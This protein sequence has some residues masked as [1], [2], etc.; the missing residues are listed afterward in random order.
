MT[1][2]NMRDVLL[3]RHPE[4]ER[5]CV[6]AGRAAAGDGCVILVEGSAGIGKTRLLDRAAHEAAAVG[7][8]VL[9]A[10]GGELEREFSYGVARQLLERPL[11]ALS[12]PARQAA[13]DGAA[14]HAAPALGLPVVTGGGQPGS[15]SLVDRAFSVPHGLYWLVANLAGDRPL[16][17]VV[18]DLQWADAA[19][20]R[21]LVHLV[22]RLDGLAVLV[23]AAVRSAEDGV[24][25]AAL[26]ALAGDRLTEVLR[27]GPLSE[28]AVEAW[29]AAAYGRQPDP[30][31][32]RACRRVTGGNP[33][34]V[35]ELVG[36]LRATGAGPGADAVARVAELGP[37]TVAR[38]I[39]MRLGGQSAEA[40]A[41][42]RAV[43]LL[44]TEAPLAHAAALAGLGVE[45]AARAADRLAAV[46]ILR[47]GRPLEFVHP[48][49]RTA[50]HADLSPAELA[51]GHARAAALLSGEGADPERIA[52]HLLATDPAGEAD[53]VA[54]M[55]A[56]AQVALERGAPDSAA[57]F[58]RRA[59]AEPPPPGE[60]AAVEGAL[61]AA[62]LRAGRV[63]PAMRHLRGAI[64]A[65]PP[66]PARA[67]WGLALAYAAVAM[68]DIVG[69]VDV[70]EEAIKE[71]EGR[72]AEL[73]RR[74]EA[75]LAVAYLDPQAIPCVAA[76]LE[77]HAS[78]RG[79]TPGER[80]LLAACARALALRE[81]PAARAVAI[82]RRAVE[83]GL[84]QDPGIEE[85][86]AAY[87]ALW[88]LIL[89]ERL[90][91]AQRLLGAGIA[92]ARKLGYSL[93]F[94]GASL[95]RALARLAAGSVLDAEA[96]AR[97]AIGALD[98]PHGAA[99]PA[100]L[101]ALVEAL[102][103]QG[104]LDEAHEALATCHE[105]L[106]SSHS[107]PV[108]RLRHS[109]ALLH[110]AAGRH[111]RALAD[112]LE[113]GRCEEVDGFISPLVPWRDVAARALC[114]LHRPDEARPLA[115]CQAT[116]ARAY[117]TKSL[118]GTSLRLDAL[119]GEPAR[120]T[121]RLEEA[122]AL[123]ARSPARLE[124][125]RALIDLGTARSRDGRRTEGRAVLEQ[126][127]EGARRCGAHALAE[128]AREELRALGARPRRR[129]FSGVEALTA[130]ERRVAAMAAQGRAN[131]E[132][133]Q[134]L[135]VTAKT[136]E[137]HL[138]RTY[139]K[140]G[141]HSRDELAGALGDRRAGDL[142]VG[143][144]QPGG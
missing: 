16:A 134:A 52:V 39:L 101:G 141:I 107:T 112:A 40:A 7:A 133:A 28:E 77:R 103:E 104:R 98:E 69:A 124:H 89:G 121:Q 76:R 79:D 9:S 53:T 118:V 37:R 74:L 49:V 108:N 139:H 22:R 33:F 117:G 45:A 82:A 92:R 3:D 127:L 29:L 72:D 5:L 100:A 11:A 144:P 78:L 142:G 2:G 131:R 105:Q 24:D 91:E 61:G 36:A 64:G 137:N 68:G 21:F 59:L 135:F 111:E 123:L 85:S 25:D 88:T 83:R 90:D 31:L 60:R 97:S 44:G 38:S 46:D 99:S 48:I 70:L 109:R 50:I 20:L 30:A 6:G 122:A 95:L 54:R 12:L 73:A 102:V 138:G 110:L 94:A 116:I 96:D 62:E 18:D 32:T 81:Q 120:R 27:P 41:L 55:W 125:A 47:A 4:I 114:A 136:V 80:L 58:L 143:A 15:P 119:V 13:L 43:A 132:I 26:A 65:Q 56:A 126:A 42:A 66:G 1:A 51:Q 140:L 75:E 19:S 130:S 71:A 63:E 14:A 87:G 10:R 8:D 86:H 23:C 35:G 113:T 106:A 17:L 115:R 84:L 93:S 129:A 34:L 57:R 67:P 128:R